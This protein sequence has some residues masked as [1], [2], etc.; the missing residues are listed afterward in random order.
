M[1]Y[2]SDDGNTARGRVNIINYRIRNETGFTEA[3]VSFGY[4]TLTRDPERNMWLYKEIDF[5]GATV[6]YLSEDEA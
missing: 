6:G 2:C 3:Q 5:G 4:L 1:D